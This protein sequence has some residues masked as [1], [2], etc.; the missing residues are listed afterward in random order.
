MTTRPQ[1]PPPPPP[2]DDALARHRDALRAR[3]PLP[4]PPVR[5]RARRKAATAATLAAV[6]ALGLLGW[7]DPAWRTERFATHAGQRQVLSLSD[8]STL[9]LD[10]STRLRVE[11]HL[12]SRRVVLE[13]GRALFEV[14]PSAWRVFTVDAGSAQVRVL[15]TAFDVRRWDEDVA[16]TV[17][18]G[19]VA[20]RGTGPDS[21]TLAPGQRADVAGGRLGPVRSVDAQA[22]TAWREG[23]FVFQRTPLA[24]VLREIE[25]YRG[26]PVRLL[27]PELAGLEVSGVYRIAN[28]DALLEL[29]PT[30]LPVRVQHA[31]DG[32]A[33]VA[34]R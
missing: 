16:V 20:V 25:R 27:Q 1:S 11:R 15:G 22:A 23:R 7:T 2:A 19:R 32:S 14:A 12:R 17:L 31:A 9:T 8:G 26:R 5:Q 21:A 13:S 6:C 10:A 18:R 28:A 34:A 30:L 24:E 33:T 29:L 3:F 4:Q